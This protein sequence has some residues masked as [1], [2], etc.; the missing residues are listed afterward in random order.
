MADLRG[1]LLAAAEEADKMQHETEAHINNLNS[2][3]N[4]VEDENNRLKKKLKDVAGALQA[5]I[6]ILSED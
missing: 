4:F 2:H 1:A 3:I 6:S 5:V